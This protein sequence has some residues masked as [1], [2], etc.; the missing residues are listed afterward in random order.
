MFK[1]L[2]V[3][4]LVPAMALASITFRECPNEAPTP[5]LL[6][7]NDCE[8]EVCEMTA[9]A[10]VQAMA[11]GIVSPVDSATATA[12]VIVRLGGLDVG[13]EIPP[14][15]VDACA[16]GIQEG[17]P[18]SSGVA[19]SYQLIDD[20]LDVPARGVAV[21]IEV[22]LTGDGGVALGCVRFDAVIN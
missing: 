5:S 21:E 8:G 16:V 4:A 6:T 11:Y 9:G 15:L 17:C 18:L 22:G 1:F 20:S 7:V 3:A 14:E 13:F 19:F 2:L 12:Y 10:P